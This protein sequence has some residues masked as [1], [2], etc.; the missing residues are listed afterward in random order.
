MS[1]PREAADGEALLILAPGDVS[2]L[3]RGAGACVDAANLPGRDGPAYVGAEATLRGLLRRARRRLA[4]ALDVEPW[5]D[6]DAAAW[7][8]GQ[9]LALRLSRREVRALER[10]ALACRAVGTV[11]GGELRERLDG[12]RRVL[13]R[14]HEKADDAEPCRGSRP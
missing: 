5:D 9:A 6:L 10:A 8:G 1:V 12:A 13:A 4:E 7:P 2:A 11:R 14:L 3:I